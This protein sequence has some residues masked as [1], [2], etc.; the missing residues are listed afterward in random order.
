MLQCTSSPLGCPTSPLQPVNKERHVSDPFL[1][2]TSSFLDIVAMSR[3]GKASGLYIQGQKSQP[4]SSRSGAVELKASHGRPKKR[5]RLRTERS[6]WNGADDW[7]KLVADSTLSTSS[8]STRRPHPRGLPTLARCASDA[9]A[10]GF[11]TIWTADST[12][13]AGDEPA[14]FANMKGFGRYWKYDWEVV[15]DHLREGV[16]DAV[17]RLWGRMLSLDIVRVVS[18]RFKGLS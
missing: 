17:F 3:P 13:V 4:G 7:N 11:E 14:Q 2:L 1:I 12:L 18:L 10:R 15:P 9:A 16:R 6:V 8:V 5:P